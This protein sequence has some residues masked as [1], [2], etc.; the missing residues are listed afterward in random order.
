[1]ASTAIRKGSSDTD[2]GCAGRLAWIDLTGP[3]EQLGQIERDGRAD[4]FRRPR[5]PGSEGLFDLDDLAPAVVTAVG[6]D[7]MGELRFAAVLT[8]GAGGAAQGVVGTA[9]VP[10]SLRMPSLRIGH[11]S[12]PRS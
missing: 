7:A 10:S 3:N 1:M 2:G 11:E 12:Y 5:G 4:R 6:A 8:Q 9:L